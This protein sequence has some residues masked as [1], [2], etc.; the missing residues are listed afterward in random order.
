MMN[1]GHV[2]A[3]KRVGSN[4]DIWNDFPL[5]DTHKGEETDNQMA[6]VNL[7]HIVLRFRVPELS[8]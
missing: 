1:I 7:G 5:Q 4:D 6:L 2:I 3:T 8:R